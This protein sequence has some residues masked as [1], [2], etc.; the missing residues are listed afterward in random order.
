M[1]YN[2]NEIN[3]RLFE[4]E[5]VKDEEIEYEVDDLEDESTDF[6]DNEII[7][8]T[9]YKLTHI[10][11][12]DGEYVGSYCFLE[13]VAN[14]YALDEDE[15]KKIALDNGYK[16]I[17]V[18][19]NEQV[20]GG[21]IIADKSCSD[22][23][24][25]DDYLKF[26]GVEAEV[27]ELK[28]SLKEDWNKEDS[29]ELSKINSTIKEKSHKDI[30]LKI[31]KALANCSSRA[32]YFTELQN[33]KYID[34]D[35]Y[36]EYKQL[37]KKGYSLASAASIISDKIYQQNESLKESSFHPDI[38]DVVR[39][40]YIFFVNAGYSDD[41]I[42]AEKITQDLIDN[43]EGYEWPVSDSDDMALEDTEYFNELENKVKFALSRLWGRDDFFKKRESLKESVDISSNDFGVARMYGPS[44]LEEL[45]KLV[46]QK[47][48]VYLEQDYNG[49]AH[50][51]W[52]AASSLVRQIKNGTAK[53]YNNKNEAFNLIEIDDES[54][55]AFKDAKE[56]K[57]GD[58][59]Y[60]DNGAYSFG[61]FRIKEI[62]KVNDKPKWYSAIR[63]ANKL[64]RKGYE[65][66]QGDVI[67]LE[68]KNNELTYNLKEDIS[69][70][71]IH[72]LSEFNYKWAIEESL[73]ESYGM[74]SDGQTEKLKRYCNKYNVNFDAAYK[75]VVTK[76]RFYQDR[77]YYKKL[78]DALERV[79]ELIANGYFNTPD[80]TKDESLLK[81]D[82]SLW[83]DKDGEFRKK[84]VTKYIIP[85][86]TTSIRRWAFSDCDNL[87]EVIIPNS[88][89]HIDEFAFYNCSNLTSIKIPNS[90][91]YIGEGVFQGSGLKNVT[92][93]NNLRTISKY[94]FAQCENLVNITLPESVINIEGHAFEHSNLKNIIILNNDTEIKIG[95]FT[96]NTLNHYLTIYTNNKY[97]K[98]VFNLPIYK[99]LPLPSGANTSLT[100]SFETFKYN[101]VD[102]FL[103][104]VNILDGKIEE[105][106][107]Y[108]E[109]KNN[110]FHHSFIFSEEQVNKMDEDECTVF[111]INNGKILIDPIGRNNLDDMLKYQLEGKIEKQIKLNKPKNYQIVIL[112]YPDIDYAEIDENGKNYFSIFIEKGHNYKDNI[113]I[114]KLYD[115]NEI[116]INNKEY[117]T[118]EIKEKI[119]E[120]IKNENNSINLKESLKEGLLK[121]GAGAGYNIKGTIS[122][123]KITKI[124]NLEIEKGQWVDYANLEVEGTATFEGYAESY[125]YG[126][127]IV[128]TPINITNIGI[129]VNL[130]DYEGVESYDKVTPQDLTSALSGS[131]EFD[132]D[133]YGGGWS[134]ST[135][136]GE[137]GGDVES[138][139]S[140]IDNIVI[141]FT[142]ETTRK[143]I[144][145]GVQGEAYVEQ[146]DVLD[147]DND[148]LDSFETEEEAIDFAKKNRGVEVRYTRWYLDSTGDFDDDINYDSE[149]VW[150][151]EYSR[152]YKYDESKKTVKKSKKLNESK[153][154]KEDWVKKYGNYSYYPKDDENKF[155][156]IKSVD[157]KIVNRIEIDAKSYDEAKNYIKNNLLKKIK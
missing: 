40:S 62:I 155:I 111:Y 113:E 100:E 82:S 141:Y 1:K 157:G 90:V 128:E 95:K 78:D 12:E 79:F 108:N 114:G 76:Y 102:Y 145:L 123:V 64:A 75:E 104:S 5:V 2:I 89:T 86:G 98:Q 59:V 149:T 150:E 11:N 99:V 74:L 16:I 7:L 37:V 10:K 29:E 118:L 21:L 65:R 20:D 125:Y 56:F 88:V 83:Y 54:R 94:A 39:D 31:A 122:N 131:V 45:E 137:I 134:H 154:L 44:T 144:D 135:F 120:F 23:H 46:Q 42:T 81:E 148:V 136:D 119:K 126:I 107:T 34:K 51:F 140:E 84:D 41:E 61:P 22:S 96:F 103:G 133:T 18:F 33:L 71:P 27:E 156:I 91:T 146:Y 35:L 101:N 15:V 97:A 127:K 139:G 85:E 153:S 147:E 53:I 28:E 92:L 110:D 8:K 60:T 143:Y 47:E 132:S 106:H 129:N 52:K 26:Y 124:N 73:K 17:K 63:K 117:D 9:I 116:E 152:S 69:F 49:K 77:G 36:K 30:L 67:I 19:P 72:E 109:C 3:K 4:D 32:E 87:K 58:L 13:E 57:V 80:R 50:G 130:L 25:K 48:K 66:W 70:K 93:S 115:N 121:Q 138:S 151:R 55:Q 43:Y 38:D 6:S 112:G 105:V 14:I 68:D 142:D 24:I